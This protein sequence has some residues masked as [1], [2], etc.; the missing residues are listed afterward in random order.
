MI[1]FIQWLSW[2]QLKQKNHCSDHLKHWQ[3]G[4]RD[5][6]E[7]KGDH[8]G[9]NSSV[10]GRAEWSPQELTRTALTVSPLRKGKILKTFIR[11][12]KIPSWN[13]RLGWHKSTGSPAR[14]LVNL[15][16]FGLALRRICCLDP[17]FLHLERKLKNTISTV[18]HFLYLMT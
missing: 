18:D 3:K 11:Q 5:C 13:C 15:N 14:L 4:C 1:V 17:Y 12:N 7:A 6:S 8:K 10:N 16:S 2:T 9:Q